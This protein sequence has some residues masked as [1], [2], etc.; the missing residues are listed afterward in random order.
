MRAWALR[1]STDAADYG[2]AGRVA[3]TIDAVAPIDAPK[4][5]FESPESRVARL[6]AWCGAIF[7]AVLS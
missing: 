4:R 7:Q 5:L 2:G 3:E 1:L 6:P